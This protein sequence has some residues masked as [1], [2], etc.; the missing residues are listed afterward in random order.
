[1]T[2]AAAVAREHNDAAANQ[3]DVP[4]APATVTARFEA[5]WREAVIAARAEFAL[6]R[7]GLEGLEG[8]LAAAA[9]E[10]EDAN[11][12]VTELEQRV[13]DEQR[14]ASGAAAQAAAHAAAWAEERADFTRKLADVR[15]RAD[16]AE[17]GAEAVEKERDRLIVERDEVRRQ[18][19]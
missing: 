15:S 3:V 12:T 9:A 1:M 19:E 8:R 4:E 14:D 18:L 7:E 16:R 17:A 13:E 6:E 2:V 5:I 11:T 10:L